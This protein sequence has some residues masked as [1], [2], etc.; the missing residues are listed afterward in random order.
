MGFLDFQTRSNMVIYL[1]FHGSNE[2]LMGIFSLDL[3]KLDG[4][5]VE[6]WHLTGIFLSISWRFDGC[7]MGFQHGFPN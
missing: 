3:M 7:V 2:V 1:I 6:P 5:L 4:Y